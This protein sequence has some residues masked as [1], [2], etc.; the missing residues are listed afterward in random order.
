MKILIVNG[1]NLNMLGLRAR[2]HYGALTLDELNA[3][4]AAYAAEKGV[5]TQFFFSNSEGELITALQ[6]TDADAVILNAG[7]YSHYS[8]ALRDCVEC[9][10]R[11]VVEVHLSDITNREAF[12]KTRVLEGVAAACF[13]GE[14]ELSYKKAVDFIIEN[15]GQNKS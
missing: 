3:A 12:R 9:I 10:P 14:K 1:A 5:R 13:Y 4:V 15:Y 6:K 7:A 2:E 8:Y 11:P